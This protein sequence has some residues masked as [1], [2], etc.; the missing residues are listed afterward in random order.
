M[1]DPVCV[2]VLKKCHGQSQYRYYLVV[3][4]VCVVALNL[5]AELSYL[6]LFQTKIKRDRVV[7][8]DAA[9]DCLKTMEH[10]R[11]C[12]SFK[13]SEISSVA[14]VEDKKSGTEH[15]EIEFTR[16]RRYRNPLRL[17][18]NHPPPVQ[19]ILFASRKSSRIK[20]YKI[21]PFSREDGTLLVN[22][23]RAL[24]DPTIP[25]PLTVPPPTPPQRP[26]PP[27]GALGACNRLPLQKRP[28]HPPR[29]S[30]PPLRPPHGPPLRRLLYFGRQ[31][32]LRQVTPP[33]C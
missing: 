5:L 29:W 27:S 24:K 31:L 1:S 30:N 14:N 11:H 10:S 20:R 4:I 19:I 25:F 3:M 23:V 2:S 6:I 7:I 12:K 13:S 33:L 32:L 15:V 28:P 21:Y 22:S 17:H 18:M 8:I 26:Q 16:W 9:N